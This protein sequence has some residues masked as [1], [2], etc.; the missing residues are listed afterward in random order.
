M[1]V[2]L[3]WEGEFERFEAGLD[4]ESA[5]EIIASLSS[6][7]VILKL[8]RFKLETSVSVAGPLQ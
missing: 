6:R 3:P 7:E 1:V 5:T 4:G 8:P 2:S